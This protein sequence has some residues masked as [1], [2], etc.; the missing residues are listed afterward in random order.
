MKLSYNDLIDFR[1]FFLFCFYIRPNHKTFQT[2]GLENLSLS[3]TLV[4]KH[5]PKFDK[6]LNILLIPRFNFV[7]L[8]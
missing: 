1:H 4:L 7:Y 6:Q 5:R 3:Y 8:P 2:H